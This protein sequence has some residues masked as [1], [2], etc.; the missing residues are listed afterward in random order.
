MTQTMEQ[1]LKRLRL[2]CMSLNYEAQNVESI[3]EKHSF[4]EFLTA[5]VD[6]EIES[7]ENKNFEKRIKAARF[8]LEKTLEEFDFDFQPSLDVKQIKSLANCQFIEKKENILLVGQ[9]GTGKSHLAVALGM[10]ALEAGYKV[11]F[12]T[13]PDLAAMLRA[14]LADQSVEE[15]T[16]ELIEPDLLILDEFG[17]TPLDRMLADPFYRII[18]S[19]YERS[20]TIVTSNKSFENWAK[21]FPDPVI[22]VAVLDR[23]IHHAHVVPIVGESYRMKDQK[24]R[25]KRSKRRKKDVD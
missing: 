2:P 18:A 3:Q 10:K 17:F 20:S 14:A 7:R 19:R 22:A 25:Q 15:K 11:R 1:K 23:M 5:L 16:R 4:L 13:I 24:K 8:P 21:D 12:I 6:G 9:C